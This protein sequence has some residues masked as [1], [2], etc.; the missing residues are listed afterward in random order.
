MVSVIYVYRFH[1]FF[2]QG[3][4]LIESVDLAPLKELIDPLTGQ[5][6]VA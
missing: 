6:S 3:F 1:Y 4:K 2:L 5:Y